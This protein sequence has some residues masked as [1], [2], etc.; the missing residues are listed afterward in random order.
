MLSVSLAW[1]HTSYS[2]RIFIFVH[3]NTLIVCVYACMFVCCFHLLFFPDKYIFCENSNFISYQNGW[4]FYGMKQQWQQYRHHHHQ[5]DELHCILRLVMYFSVMR[6]RYT[7]V[8][9]PICI[10]AVCMLVILN[11]L[12]LPFFLSVSFFSWYENLSVW[13]V[14]PDLFSFIILS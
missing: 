4:L 7:R 11:S 8:D 6:R 12:S 1:W 5:H 9:I 2:Y 10:H 3:L 13:S 14:G